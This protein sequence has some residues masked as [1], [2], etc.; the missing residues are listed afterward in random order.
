Q[1]GRRLA[2]EDQRGGVLEYQLPGGLVGVG[3]RRGEQ[4]QVARGVLERVHDDDLHAILIQKRL[5]VFAAALVVVVENAGGVQEDGLA[6]RASVDEDA[7]VR[8]ESPDQVAAVLV[9]VE[10]GLRDLVGQEE[11]GGA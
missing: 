10:Q 8:R 6:D 7:L 11:V 2:H 5:G 4:V 9:G 1:P 3:Q